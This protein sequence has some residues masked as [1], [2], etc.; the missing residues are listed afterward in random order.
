VQGAHLSK[1][2]HHTPN[3]VKICYAGMI[4]LWDIL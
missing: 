1:F 4:I 2:P 3:H